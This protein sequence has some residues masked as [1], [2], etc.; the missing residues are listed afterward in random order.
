MPMLVTCVCVQTKTKE[1]HWMAF[2]GKPSPLEHLRSAMIRRVKW[3]T[4]KYGFHWEVVPSREHPRSHDN[5]CQVVHG[6]IQI[7]S[8]IKGILRVGRGLV[9]HDIYSRKAAA[10]PITAIFL[11]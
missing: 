1:R 9:T 11:Y 8:E 7:T 3:F 10:V 4:K 2:T 5:T 6:Q